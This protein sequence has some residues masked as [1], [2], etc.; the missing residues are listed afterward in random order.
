MFNLC[1][2]QLVK[3]C[4]CPTILTRDGDRVRSNGK[5]GG[6]MNKALPLEKLRGSIFGEPLPSS[7]DNTHLALI[8][9]RPHISGDRH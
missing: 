7:F 6:L 9:I 5:F 2:L 4:H 8:E 1:V 3:F